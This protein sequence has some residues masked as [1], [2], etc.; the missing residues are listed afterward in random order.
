M[1]RF[2]LIDPDKMIASEDFA[3]VESFLKSCGQIQ[4]GWHYIVDLV[5]IYSKVKNWPRK[6]KVLDAGGGRGFSQILLAEMGFEVY[7]IDLW[8]LSPSR[9]WLDRYGIKHKILD[10][11]TSTSYKDHIANVNLESGGMRSSLKKWLM[12]NSPAILGL[13]RSWKTTTFH[14]RLDQWRYR[15]QMDNYPVGHI[16]WI[17]G[18]L[19]HLPEIPRG[20]FDAMISLSSLEHIPQDMLD[21]GVN[22]IRRILKESA[23]WAV[24]T[25]GTEK[26]YTW[27]HEPSKGLCFSLS[28][29]NKYF[30]AE[31]IGSVEPEV[32]LDKYRENNYL[33]N[34][35]S[36]IYKKSGENGMPWGKWD[37]QYFP[38]GL[39]ENLN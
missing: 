29:L 13:L 14:K 35:L 5:W 16:E 15:W 2:E 27:F 34:N 28:D 39:C 36:D 3:I 37:P 12:A 22:E 32:I 38:V 23:H 24:T 18:N 9:F 6:I 8:H 7:N 1:L 17:T 21:K 25:S 26:P 19:C 30:N 33:K 31:R 11:Y 20:H 4:L 10:S